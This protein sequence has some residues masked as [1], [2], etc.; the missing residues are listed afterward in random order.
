MKYYTLETNEEEINMDDLFSYFSSLDSLNDYH[1]GVIMDISGGGIKFSSDVK[2]ESGSY[3][4]SVISLN[5][6]RM[7][8]VCKIIACEKSQKV[9]DKYINRA[10][11]IFKNISDREKIVRFVFDEE[12]KARQR[13]VGE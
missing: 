4:I 7:M 8:I 1:Y 12:R 13:E 6:E 10:K 11:F 3:I 9:S 5:G 2:N